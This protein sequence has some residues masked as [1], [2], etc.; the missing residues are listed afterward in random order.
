MI[1]SAAELAG[2][3]TLPGLEKRET[4]GTRRTS[5]LKPECGLSGPPAEKQKLI[6]SQLPV[7]RFPP[8][9][10]V[11]PVYSVYSP[12]AEGGAWVFA[13]LHQRRINQPSK[14]RTTAQIARALQRFARIAVTKA[15]MPPTIAIKNQKAALM[16]G[17]NPRSWWPHSS[18]I[19]EA[20][21]CHA[22]AC[23][24]A[25]I[26]AIYVVIGTSSSSA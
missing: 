16:R 25:P 18:S 12:D 14:Q 6:S 8:Q 17:R 20:A 23:Q 5:P 26:P 21:N 22:T 10:S 3:I 24:P 2:R 13:R 19:P 11:S 1:K 4:W 9:V 15:E 7:P